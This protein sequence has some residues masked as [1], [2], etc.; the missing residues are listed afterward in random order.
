[1]RPPP[2]DRGR[3]L[4]RKASGEQLI[5]D[6]PQRVDIAADAGF[7]FSNLLWRHVGRRTGSFAAATGIVVAEGQPEVRDAHPPSSIE[8]DVGWLQI[9][10]QQSAI[11]RG[12]ETRADL[13]C[14]LQSFVR[15]Q[16][17]YAAQ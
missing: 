4:I 5:K 1:M 7:A 11:M 13:V 9:T 6:K 17:A 2:L 8:H 14:G 12:R 16:A 15:G 3:C 10:M